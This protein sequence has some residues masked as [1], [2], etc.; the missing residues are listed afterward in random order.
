[1]PS[2][3]PSDYIANEFTSSGGLEEVLTGTLQNGELQ[4][5]L[6]NQ[7]KYFTV[8]PKPFMLFGAYNKINYTAVCHNACLMTNHEQEPKTKSLLC[9][10]GGFSR[11]GSIFAFLLSLVFFVLPFAAVWP[12]FVEPKACIC[13]KLLIFTTCMEFLLFLWHF[14]CIYI[15][16][17]KNLEVWLNSWYTFCVK[18]ET[19]Q[20]DENS[21]KTHSF[22]RLRGKLQ[23]IDVSV[24]DLCRLTSGLH[25][26]TATEREKLARV[27]EKHRLE[28][29]VI[30]LYSEEFIST[31]IMCS[32]Y[33]IFVLAVLSAA[34]TA[35][36]VWK[37]F[38]I[39][40]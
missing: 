27:V 33:G 25:Q 17:V 34:S 35:V 14:Y 29:A 7:H 28:Q 11:L 15:I 19:L 1:M 20:E 40:L 2:L 21:A 9:F 39:W 6:N 38:K 18:T 10:G 31:F 26:L 5:L 12:F 4:S 16:K 24:S 23:V 37:T 13:K 36:L 3:H 32:M 30:I 8:V 22:F